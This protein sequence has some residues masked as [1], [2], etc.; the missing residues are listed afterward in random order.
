MALRITNTEHV[1]LNIT[2]RVNNLRH[3]CLSLID[4]EQVGCPH[5]EMI[6]NKDEAQQIISHLEEQFNIS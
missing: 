4:N 6:I 5:I 3:V 2:N 1:D